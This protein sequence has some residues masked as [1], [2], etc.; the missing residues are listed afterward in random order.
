MLLESRFGV[1]GQQ[2]R[3]QSARG[4]SE[5]RRLQADQVLVWS[6]ARF[7]ADV[8]R[9]EVR[10][11][12]AV[13][14]T[15]SLCYR[16]PGDDLQ[17]VRQWSGRESRQLAMCGE[18]PWSS[19]GSGRKTSDGLWTV[20]AVPYVSLSLEWAGVRALSAVTVQYSRPAQ[21]EGE[22]TRG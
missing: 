11:C 17:A 15:A 9:V 19:V 21:A 3:W 2:I 13:R 4:E 16:C 12:S 7:G 10:R 20:S 18:D 5:A 6:S 22:G 1:E 14:P 8:G